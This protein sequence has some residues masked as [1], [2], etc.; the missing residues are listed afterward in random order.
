[1]IKQ[2]LALFAATC[3][4]LLLT[5][6]K[7]APA[8]S[9]PPS[10]DWI[11][12]FGTSGSEQSATVSADIL[13]NVF[14]AGL[15]GGTFSGP[16]INAGSV[17]LRKYDATGTASW[18]RQIAPQEDNGRGVVAA[19]GLGNVYVGG[20]TT[21]NVAAPNAGETDY[22]LRKY[23]TSGNVLWTRQAGSL[24]YDYLQKATVDLSG[25]VYLTGYTAYDLAGP[26]L[27]GYDAFLI[28]YDSLGNKIWSRQIGTT[29]EDLG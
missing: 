15:T 29:G 9:P 28:K 14:V 13:G 17:Y 23:D 18:T 8:A 1:M 2:P 21:G 16:P 3:L 4:T 26:N 5:L 22:F 7:S 12:Q 10:V 19:D 6:P 27:G 11:R 20:D 25:N 24:S